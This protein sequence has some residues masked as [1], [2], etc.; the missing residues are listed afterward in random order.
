MLMSKYRTIGRWTKWGLPVLAIFQVG[1]CFYDIP[2]QS[3]LQN[4]AS[5]S[6]SDALSIVGETVA[7]NVLGF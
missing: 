7:I 5:R 2:W 1:G 6:V 3:I 4:E